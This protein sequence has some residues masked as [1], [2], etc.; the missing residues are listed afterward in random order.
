[1]YISG[2]F[3][4]SSQWEKET[5]IH[6]IAS[7][8]LSFLNEDLLLFC[9]FYYNWDIK[10]SFVYFQYFVLYMALPHD[11]HLH[12]YFTSAS[13]KKLL[14]HVNVE[15]DIYCNVYCIPS[16]A[17]SFFLFMHACLD[18]F[19]ANEI[20]MLS[21]TSGDSLLFV[22]KSRGKRQLNL[23]SCFRSSWSL[24]ARLGTCLSIAYW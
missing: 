18:K 2:D 21:S 24:Y 23:L 8:V 22:I 5:I 10:V 7:M 15:I 9:I 1:M 19:S 6:Y 20:A 11:L 4:I 12:K 14:N 13:F 3:L 16:I 17:F